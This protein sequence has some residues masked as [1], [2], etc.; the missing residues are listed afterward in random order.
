[1]RLNG[2]GQ[3]TIPAEIRE[4]YGLHPGDEMDVVEVGTTLQIVRR[5]G[6]ATRGQRAVQRLRGS[7]TTS[8]TT[9]EIMGLLRDE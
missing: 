8:M 1:M 9:D 4:K 5:E 6:G 2:K 3:L 7:A